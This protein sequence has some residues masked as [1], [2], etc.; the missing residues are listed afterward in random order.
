MNFAQECAVI[1]D[2]DGVIVDSKDAHFASFDLLGREEGYTCTAE[3]FRDIFGRRNEEIFPMLYGHALPPERVAWLAERKEAMFRAMVAGRVTPLPGVRDL[4]PA[5]ATAGFHRALGTSTPRANVD[6]ILR[7]LGLAQ[8]FETIVSAED[9]TVGK[10]DPRVFSLGAERLGIPPAH[11]V[12]VEDAVAGVRAALNGGMKALAV[13]TNHPRASL[14][15]A[16][17]V[18]DSLA[19]VGP[20]DFLALIAG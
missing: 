3:Q 16:Q 6:L 4:L 10:P 18:V 9:V 2:L 13:T 19:E 12:V 17:R 8:Y 20:E 5:L 1:F 11:C 14:R 15:A 7:E